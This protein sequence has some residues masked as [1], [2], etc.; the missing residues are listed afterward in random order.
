MSGPDPV[1]VQRSID[2]ARLLAVLAQLVDWHRQSGHR[3][4]TL[5]RPGLASDAIADKL[6]AAGLAPTPELTALYG[7]H[8]GTDTGDGLEYPLIWYHR[9][10][11][12]DEALTLRRERVK[13][14]GPDWPADW[15]PVFAFE[16]EDYAVACPRGGPVYFAFLEDTESPA[17]YLSLTRL[18]ETQYEGLRGCHGRGED[19]GFALELDVAD[20]ATLHAQMNPGLPFPYAVP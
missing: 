19:N 1:D 3:V 10:L 20:Y 12:L 8:D 7:W 16:G 5:L 4:A 13:L 17:V 9:F 2:P 14:L 15:L 6:A 18:L 11:P